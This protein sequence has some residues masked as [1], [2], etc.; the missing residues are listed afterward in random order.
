[1][2]VLGIRK[3]CTLPHPRDPRLLLHMPACLQ[4]LAFQLAI[5]STICST[6]TFRQMVRWQ[7]LALKVIV[8][9][10]LFSLMTSR[11]IIIKKRYTAFT[12]SRSSK[13]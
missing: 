11:I 10:K 5:L 13:L 2:V 3:H 6:A 4:R 9:E 7:L 1:V 8:V 12:Q